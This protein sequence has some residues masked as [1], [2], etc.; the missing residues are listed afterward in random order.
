LNHRKDTF[1][2]RTAFNADGALS[3]GGWKDASVKNFSC[4]VL[5]L[6]ALQPRQCK[7]GTLGLACLEL[8][9]TRLYIAPE[10]AHLQ[11]R[12][13]PQCQ[14]LPAQGRG[15]QLC[16]LRKILQSLR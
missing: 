9:Q 7:Q 15:A 10:H 11:V 5:Q 13:E 12:P 2:P 16:A 14:R 6:Q 4:Q 1:V 8:S 3:K